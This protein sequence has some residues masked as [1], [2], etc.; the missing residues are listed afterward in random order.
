MLLKSINFTFSVVCF[1]E[2]WLDDLSIT[3]DSMCQLPNYTSNHEI[4]VIVKE[5]LFLFTFIK[6]LSLKPD[7]IYVSIIKI[8]KQLLWQSYQIKGEYRSSCPEV[9]LGKG[10][11]KICSN[12]TGEHPCWSLIS[13]KL[14]CNFIEI[15][16]RHGYSS[17]NLLHI[18]CTFS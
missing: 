4:R 2:T 13:I 11:L 16:L 1:S 15:T 17:V 6:G 8:W 7:L 10:V 18:S 12:F 3:W 9:F 14:L 5:V